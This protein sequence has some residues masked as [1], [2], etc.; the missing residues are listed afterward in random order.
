MHSDRTEQE[1]KRHGCCLNMA[2][3]QN[4][5][6]GRACKS[7]PGPDCD[8]PDVMSRYC[9]K[10]VTTKLHGHGCSEL[11]MPSSACAGPQKLCTPE[12]A[13]K[14]DVACENLAFHDSD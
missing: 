6:S 7:G 10:T 12:D 3:K 14:H 2:C 4:K 13:C 5:S 11:G 9:T 8:V 1:S